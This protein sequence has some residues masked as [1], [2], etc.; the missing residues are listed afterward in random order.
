LKATT[1][2]C[3]LFCCSSCKRGCCCVYKNQADSQ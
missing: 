3:V 2:L 1:K